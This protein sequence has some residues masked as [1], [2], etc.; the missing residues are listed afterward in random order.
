[1]PHFTVQISPQGA[2]VSAAIMVSSARRQM[3]ETSGQPVPPPQM[4]RALIDTGASI[5]GVDPAILS[6]LVLTPTGE[7]DIHTPSTGGVPVHTAT[8]DVCI[9]ILAGR[10]GDMH[11]ISETVQ[12]TATSLASH[13][14][15]ALIGT[16]I[17]RK[18]ILY[19]NGAD[20][21]FTLAY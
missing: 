10:Q 6:A 5:S 1:M 3:L 17:L 19:Y 12:V 8:Y 21:L 7:A 4:I 20:G 16:D 15:Q 13:G 11:F 14:F 2:I 9:G 18:C